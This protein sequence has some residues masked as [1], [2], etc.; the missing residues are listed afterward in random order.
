[1]VEAHAKPRVGGA[2]EREG[3]GAAGAVDGGD[4]GFDGG[5]PSG[6]QEPQ[7][8]EQLK[9]VGFGGDRLELAAGPRAPRA[10]AAQVQEVQEEEEGA[11]VG[12][13]ETHSLS[14]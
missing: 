9:Q 10:R 2:R 5:G 3:D 11:R 7:L 4:G 6:E 8:R 13:K 12:R 14:N 1:M